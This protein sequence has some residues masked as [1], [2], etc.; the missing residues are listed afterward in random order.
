MPRFDG[1]SFENDI[2]RLKLELRGMKYHWEGVF[3]RIKR[4]GQVD[5]REGAHGCKYNAH[6]SISYLSSEIC[7]SCRESNCSCIFHIC[8]ALCVYREYL[9]EKLGVHVV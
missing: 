9:V 7:K 3:P 1:G 6:L 4:L 2:R 8:I 5:I